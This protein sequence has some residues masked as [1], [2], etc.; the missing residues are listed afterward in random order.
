MEKAKILIVEDEAIIAMELE[1]NLQSLG[2]QVTSIV[3]TGDKAIEKAEKL[4]PDIILMDLKMPVMDGFEATRQLKASPKTETI[5][6]IA[7]SASATIE[8][9]S[10]VLELGF[11]C[12]LTKPINVYKLFEQL[13]KYVQ[14][15]DKRNPDKDAAKTE[16]NKTIDETNEEA[17]SDNIHY[18][19]ECLETKFW[20]QWDGF[21]T[22]QPVK[23]V[24][25]FGEE[26]SELGQSNK[27]KF[28]EE[29]GKSLIIHV[30][31]FDIKNMRKKLDEFPELVKRLKSVG[32]KSM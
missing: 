11:E 7:L 1:S 19:I 16:L 12:F 22:K 9:K 13:A 24:K 14:S 4:Q 15:I 5:P 25:K 17:I 26:L 32:G 18:L 27:L 29:Y 23:E 3:D 20:K 2:Y 30:T 10:K 28:L 8:D 21:Q 6:V 31:N